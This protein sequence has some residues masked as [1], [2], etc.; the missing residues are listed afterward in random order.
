M[1]RDGEMAARHYVRLV[2]GNIGTE[3][4]VGVVQSLLAQAAAAVYVYGDPANRGTA[5]QAL[6]EAAL[7]GAR[8]AA[9]G[10]DHQLA[11][12]RTFISTA[13]SDDHLATVR[14]LLDGDVPFQDLAVDTE[15]R[16]HVIRSLAAAGAVDEELIRAEQ[17][18]DPTDRGTRHAAAARAARPTA[19]AKADAWRTVV[20]DGELPLALVD[21]LMAG[22]QQL[23]QEDVLRPYATEFFEVL[24]RVWRSRALP[25]ALAFARRLYPHVIVEPSTIELTD[26]YLA[27]DA[28]PAPIRRLLLEGKDGLARALRTRSVDAT[29]SFAEPPKE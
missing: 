8:R 1:L 21:E 16:W 24:E 14:G 9:P 28:V 22:F 5:G 4:Q 23:T 2:L 17:D 3:T 6:A 26:R 13:R 25:D 18:R 27:D 15:L 20:E 11:W 10:S 29:A 19:E 12:A 7:A